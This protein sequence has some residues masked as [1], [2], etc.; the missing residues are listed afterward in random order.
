[1]LQYAIGDLILQRRRRWVRRK[2]LDDLQLDLHALRADAFDVYRHVISRRKPLPGVRKAGQ[3]RCQLNEAA[4][5]FH[6]ADDAPHRLTGREPAGVFHPGAQQ[7]LVG[8]G[9][10]PLLLIGGE[11]CGQ[12]FLSHL[13]AVFR[14]RDPGHG[15]LLD[16]QHGHHAA[17]NIQKRAKGCKMRHLGRHHC[18]RRQL[19]QR[20]QSLLLWDS[21]GKMGHWRTFFIALQGSDCKAY[22][23]SNF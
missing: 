19:Q 5:L 7:L 12:N 20:L 16:G 10:P 18:S 2:P 14:V 22:S 6:A 3:I 21:A 13:E 4:V 23:L 8:H 9:Q 1:M 17:A 15:D 11:H